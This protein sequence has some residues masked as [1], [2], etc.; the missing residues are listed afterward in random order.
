MEV[1]KERLRVWVWNATVNMAWSI[2]GRLGCRHLEVWGAE[3][4]G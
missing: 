3:G 2:L 4:A 1:M